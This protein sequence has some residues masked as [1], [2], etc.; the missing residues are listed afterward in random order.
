MY[1]ALDA[2]NVV[3]RSGLDQAGLLQTAV[4][5]QVDLAADDMCPLGLLMF[6]CA[7]LG[8]RCSSRRREWRLGA[9]LP[10]LRVCSH[11]RVAFACIHLCCTLARKHIDRCTL[12]CPK[13]FRLLSALYCYALLLRVVFSLR[14]CLTWRLAPLSASS[15]IFQCC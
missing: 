3:S 15:S 4:G 14:S 10:R 12:F 2:Q 8:P 9:A 1:V 13:Q 6:R 11:H 7:G 5:Q